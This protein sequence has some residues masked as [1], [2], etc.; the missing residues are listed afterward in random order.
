MVY[1]KEGMLQQTEHAAGP[2]HSSDE[3]PS[4]TTSR[5]R[6]LDI[7]DI[8]AFLKSYWRV[9]AGWTITAVTFALAYA[10]TTTPLYLRARTYA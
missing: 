6:G 8:H 4:R 3:G 2:W 7:H 5:L 9:I 1:G 10:F